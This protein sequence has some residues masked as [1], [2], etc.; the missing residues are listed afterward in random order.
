MRQHVKTIDL[1]EVL[2]EWINQ[3]EIDN[4]GTH[5]FLN[6]RELDRVGYPSAKKY[7]EQKAG[8]KK[9]DLTSILT[10]S[11]E[12]TSFEKAD[13]ILTGLG[14]IHEF[15]GRVPVYGFVEHTA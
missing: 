7:L 2:L 3:Y 10:K 12:T 5:A 14:K 6:W 15:H 13:K 9:G 1:A 4:L 11:T 8:L